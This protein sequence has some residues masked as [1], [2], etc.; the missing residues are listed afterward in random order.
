MV[1][2]NYCDAYI[3]KY[4]IMSLFGSQITGYKDIFHGYNRVWMD[5]LLGW[6]VSQIWHTLP[7]GFT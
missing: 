2:T 7:G 3:I 1:I 5:Y 4:K 6:W